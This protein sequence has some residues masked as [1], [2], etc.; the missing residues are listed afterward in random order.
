M[1]NLTANEH[2]SPPR[3]DKAFLDQMTIVQKR[4][5]A[6]AIAGRMREAWGVKKN[7]ELAQFIGGHKR[8]MGN[9]INAGAI[10]WE[11]LYTCHLQTGRSLDWL[12]NGKLPLIE[13]TPQAITKLES[14]IQDVLHVCERVEFIL[15]G[16]P[17]GVKDAAHTIAKE[18]LAYL[19]FVKK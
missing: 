4:D 16:K 1:N 13:A 8:M 15:K 2:H 5:W 9:W 7:R 17:N 3:R 12:Y 11:V 10:P 19:S 18:V 6:K 14:L